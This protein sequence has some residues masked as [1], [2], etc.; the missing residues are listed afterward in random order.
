MLEQVF[1]FALRVPVLEPD[2]EVRASKVPVVLGDL[3]FEDQVIAERI[4][5]EL[6]NQA[7]ILMRVATIVG[8]DQVGL[9]A[10]LDLLEALLHRAAFVGQ[11]GIAE[12]M[13]NDL[14][15]RSA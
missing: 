11:V 2:E 12:R 3:E 9:K 8:K 6:R 15:L 4:P 7:V 10:L 14:A 1:N 13:E 5:C